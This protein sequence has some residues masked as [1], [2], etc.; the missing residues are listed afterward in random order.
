MHTPMSSAV[1]RNTENEAIIESS[2][3]RLL[4]AI[5]AEREQL[6][7][8]WLSIDSDTKNTSQE[9]D[10]LRQETEEWCMT[11]RQ[12]VDT[13]YKRLDKMREKMSILY[14]NER[15][16]VLQVNCCGRHFSIPKSALC[17]IE[18]SYLNHMF[19]DAF[20][21]NVPRDPEGRF[22]LDFN[23]DCFE[24]I[25][26][27]LQAVQLSPNAPVPEVPP[28]QQQ[29]MDILAE[30]LNLKIFL[31]PNC[32]LT[33][34]GT[35]LQVN[36]NVVEAMHPGWQVISARDPLPM[37]GASYFEVKILAN[38]D[39]TKG[40]LAFGICGHQPSGNEVFSIQLPDAILYNSH[41]G[42]VSQCVGM[43]N[44]SKRIHFSAGSV[45]GLKHDISTRSLHW[46]FNRLCVGSCTIQPEVC[47]DFRVL[48]PVFALYVPGQKI[49]VDFRAI[50]PSATHGQKI[51]GERQA[52]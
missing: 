40:G 27:Y 19:S 31:R 39:P 33:G 7:T 43:E 12:K 48:F 8:T 10:R 18:G 46:Y 29:N 25:V 38:P 21:H 50:A 16:E 3:R 20:I 45:V 14:P 26:K 13:L 34:H 23:A 32:I 42:L 24:I 6:R 4:A 52:Q 36:G 30:A 1:P 9:L 11:E 44:V 49:Q 22:F 35:S 47:E 41:A 5:E 17:H 28:Q 2:F 51:T 37:S 15:G